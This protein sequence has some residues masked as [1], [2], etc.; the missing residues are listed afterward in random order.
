MSYE[1]EPGKQ[2]IPALAQ[3]SLFPRVT[4]PAGKLVEGIK[5]CFLIF[6]RSNNLSDPVSQVTPNGEDRICSHDARTD[7]IGRTALTESRERDHKI[8]TLVPIAFK[9][10]PEEVGIDQE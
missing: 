3:V 7:D 9:V 5:R 8:S 2:N 1:I 4:M 10:P 6:S